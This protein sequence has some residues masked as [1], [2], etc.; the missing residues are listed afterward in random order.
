MARDEPATAGELEDLRRENALLR[1]R[2]DRRERELAGTAP[3]IEQ[4]KNL[5]FWDFTP[6]EVIPDDSWVAV[7]R[8][9]AMSLMDALA[10]IDHWNPWGTAIEARPQP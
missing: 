3:L 8:A 1:L 7:D 2:V 5:S 10:A 9:K 6:Y 4:A